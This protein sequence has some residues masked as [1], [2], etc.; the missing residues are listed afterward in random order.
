MEEGSLFGPEKDHKVPI[1]EIPLAERMRPDTLDDYA[2]QEHILGPGKPLRIMLEGGKVP[3]CILYG[4]PGVGKTTLVRIMSKTTGRELL[5]INAVSAKVETL[6]T[7]VDKAKTSKRMSGR[8]AIAFVDEIYHFNT[9]QQNVLLPSVETGDIILVGT[10][11]ENPWFEINKTLLSRMVVYTLKPLD[12]EDIVSLLEKA[13]SDKARG[14]GMLEVAA[15]KSVIGKL[16]SLAGGDARQA[17]TRLE[18][19][20]SSVA[21][22]GGREVTLKIIAESTGMATQRYDRVSDDHYAV[23]SALIKSLRGSDPDA[24]LYWLARM[25]AAGDDLRF[26][27]RRLCIFA[28]ED[29]GLADPMALVVAQNAAAAVDRVGLPEADII[30]GQAVVYLASAPKSNSSYLGIRAA[31]KAV[32]EGDLMEVPYHLRNDGEGYQYPHDSPGHWV[33]QAYLPEQRRFYYPGKLGAEARIKE[34]LKLFWK[35]FADDP[36]DEQGS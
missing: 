1:Y 36:A 27:C 22:G 5:E 33:P 7:L 34:R 16:A 3:S 24:A 9:K 25:L 29:V 30:L 2:G 31:M 20:A 28:S 14:L 10:T 26:I 11:T 19:A 23:I 13:L 6:R 4:P 12:E 15:D 21:L 17:L 8:S 32:E 18:A 35:R